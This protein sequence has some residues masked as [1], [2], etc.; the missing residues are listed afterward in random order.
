MK[1]RFT[2]DRSLQRDVAAV[3]AGVRSLYVFTRDLAVLDHVCW[4]LA[5]MFAADSTFDADDFLSR[6]RHLCDRTDV[7]THERESDSDERHVD[8]SRG[9][10]DQRARAAVHAEWSP[11]V[12]LRTGG[13]PSLP[14]ER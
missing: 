13:E 2:Y 12:F 10:L 7:S 11:G 9:Q 14:A 5:D 1:S 3:M 6:C 8:D 4:E